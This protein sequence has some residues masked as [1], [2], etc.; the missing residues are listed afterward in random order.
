MYMFSSERSLPPKEKPAKNSSAIAPIANVRRV[1]RPAVT[2]SD[3]KTSIT[4]VTSNTV[5]IAFISGVTPV[6]IIEYILIGN[7][8]APGP[9]TK[10]V[11]T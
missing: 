2:R 9:A 3:T 5:E 4:V 1:I 10:L 6:F 8:V 7:V 11:M